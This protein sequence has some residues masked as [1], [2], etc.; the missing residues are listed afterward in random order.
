MMR[1]DGESAAIVVDEDSFIL[2]TELE[3]RKAIRLQYPVS[4]LAIYPDVPDGEGVPEPC[5]LGEQLA[6][7][8]S[9]LVRSTDL[10]GL[11]A[12]S[13]NLHALLVDVPS[14]DLPVVIQRISE[15]VSRH[16]FRFEDDRKAVTV[17]VGSAC[18]PTTAVSSHGLL[19]EAGLRAREPRPDRGG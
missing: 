17:R 16:R 10:I 5:R 14:E 1:R 6:G 4:M 2:V 7:V 19:A 8:I 13:A 9:R 12:S 11:S 18:F 3:V 15:E